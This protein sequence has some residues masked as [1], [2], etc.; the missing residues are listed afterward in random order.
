MLLEI[1]HEGR[2]PCAYCCGVGHTSLMLAVDVAVGVADV[3]LPELCQQVDASTVGGPEFGMV[4]FVV[5]DIG[6]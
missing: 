4:L 5:M 1:G 2:A 6:R 3:D